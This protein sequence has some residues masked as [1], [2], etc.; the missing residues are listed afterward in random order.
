M[1]SNE[2]PIKILAPQS[3]RKTL[4]RRSLFQAGGA[5]AGLAIL[6]ACGDDKISSS[7]T[8]APGTAAGAA[9]GGTAGAPA[10]GASDV[11]DSGTKLGVAPGDYSRVTNKSSG[12]LSMYTWGAYNDPDI[13][14][15]LAEKDL[16]IKM[17]VDYY[18][19]NE[20]LITKLQASKGTTGFDIVVP[21]GPYIPQMIQ[22]GLLEKFDKTK[23][24]NMVNVDP[25]YLAQAWDPTNDYS[26]CKDWGSTG[27]F[28]N[29]TII[30]TEI[31]TWTDFISVCQG[32]GSKN[33][34]VLDTPANI[35]G[36]YFWANGIDWNTEKTEDLD[37]AEKFLVNDFATHIKAFDSYPST[38]LAEGAYAVAM[39]WNGDARAAYADIADAGGNVD[40]W[41]WGLGAPVT[42]L[43]MD[44]YCIATGSPNPDAAHAW[45]D[46]ILIPEVSIK[47]LDFHGYNSGMK[48]MDALLKELKPDLKYG[49]MIFFAD[50][51]IKTM[52]TQKIT[53]SQD[54]LTDIYNK[55]KAA[56]GS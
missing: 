3:F 51:L 34:A 41:V 49:D 36:M 47:D 11:G 40:D 31:K 37:A 13:V 20:D 10:A 1:S 29:K 28:Y 42:E 5:A 27:W 19:S 54:R 18:T 21:T 23:L 39:A 46:W 52:R 22:N 8:A 45:I 56:A 24:P 44:N 17:K 32:E 4:S 43:W 55:I 7:N 30:K 12:N 25:N 2:E 6:A 48:G 14:G 15:A 53:S 38:K 16:A 26:V 33:C 50:E 9:P 35:A